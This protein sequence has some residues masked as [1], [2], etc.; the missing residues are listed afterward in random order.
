MGV[1]PSLR[2]GY[3]CSWWHPRDSTWSYTPLGMLTA[4]CEEDGVTVSPIDAQRMLVGKAALSATHALVSRNAWQYGRLNRFLVNRKVHRATRRA[5]LDAVLAI[6]ET[7]PR[8]DTPIFLYQ[9][10]GFGVALENMERLGPTAPNLL[11]SSPRRLRQL[12]LEQSRVYQDSA[13]VF[14]MGRWFADWLVT[15]GGLPNDKVHAI[16]GGL[17]AVP[18]SRRETL[19]EGSR[20]RL[21]FVGRDF[22]RKGGDLV[23]DAAA[24]LRAAGHGPFSLTIVGPTS[25]PLKK[26]P[27]SWITFRGAMEPSEI[28]RLWSR[29]DILVLPSWFEAYGLVF[30]EARAAGLPCVARRAFA[31]P[32]LVPEGRAG[33]LVAEGGGSD[34]VAEAIYAV[35]IDDALFARVGQE[36]DQVF[37]D[38]CWKAVASR[39]ITTVRRVIRN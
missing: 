21:L 6:G 12:A 29:H 15:Q 2:L 3:A 27:P 30:L 5:D 22:F 25:W 36:A 11:R 32:E 17:N 7:E 34:E 28:S 9:D 38:N 20:H 35:S 10:M 13:G 14:T 4:L 8:S 24:G 33:R 39:A 37:R 1:R 18:S 26:D 23:I 19:K 31:M 16:G